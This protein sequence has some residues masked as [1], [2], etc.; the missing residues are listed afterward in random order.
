MGGDATTDPLPFAGFISYSRRN[1]RLAAALQFG[2]EQLAKPSRSPRRFNVFLDTDDIPA[3]GTLPERLAQGLGAA[4]KLVVL[5]SRD[6]A[7]S[8]WVGK[9]LEYWTGERDPHGRDIILVVLDEILEWDEQGGAS[10]V[11]GWAAE[12]LVELH[13][14]LHDVFVDQPNWVDLRE[15]GALSR[16]APGSP[17]DDAEVHRR[18]SLDDAAFKWHVARIQAPLIGPDVKPSDIVGED[19]EIHRAEERRRRRRVQAIV[20]LAA[21]AI[22]LGAIATV[23]GLISAA[24]AREAL[25]RQLATQSGDPATGLDLGPLLAIEAFGIDRNADSEGA[26]V[27]AAARAADIDVLGFGHTR[28]IRSVDVDADGEVVV[29]TDEAG[30][31]VVRRAADGEVIGSA[32]VTDAAGGPVAASDAELADAEGT[33]VV[34]G[35][36][37]RVHRFDLTDPS[38]PV[39][40]EPFEPIAGLGALSEIELLDGGRVAVVGGGLDAAG[41]CTRNAP[42][43]VVTVDLVTGDQIELGTVTGCTYSLA[44]ADGVVAAGGRDGRVTVVGSD[45][46]AV[47]LTAHESEVGALAISRDGRRLASAGFDGWVRIWSLPRL[48]TTEPGVRPTADV[49]ALPTSAI[50][51]S[52]AFSADGEQLAVGDREGAVVVLSSGTGGVDREFSSRH[53]GDVRGLVFA[54]AGDR[55]YSGASD[56]IVVAWRIGG[57]NPMTSVLHRDEAR[58]TTSAESATVVAGGSLGPADEPVPGF[59]DWIPI[60][61]DASAERTATRSAVFA[62]AIHRGVLAA[63]LVDG[64]IELIDTSSRELIRRIELGDR[65]CGDRDEPINPVR[66]VALGDRLLVAGYANGAV[67]VV[68]D[69]ATVDLAAASG[70]AALRCHEVTG[71]AWGVALHPDGDLVAATNGDSRILLWSLPDDERDVVAGP[72]ELTRTLSFDPSGRRVVA[73]GAGGTVAVLDAATGEPVQRALAG[74]TGSVVSA[75]FSADGRRLVTAGTDGVIRLWDVDTGL[76][77]TAPLR[78]SSGL[79]RGASWAADDQAVLAVG[80]DGAVVWDLRPAA[81]RDQVC[82]VVRRDMTPTEWSAYVGDRG[83]HTTCGDR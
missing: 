76:P 83:W 17:E 40:L 63:G 56:G 18:L 61:G 31:V 68:D 12:S 42:S 21:V 32:A 58:A 62:V 2:L 82:R 80:P 79:L 55:L 73:G 8:Y 34:A 54:P 28:S 1:R 72:A 66:S 33:L 22:V 16:V 14:V 81:L 52:L 4:G 59:V 6:A 38:R 70:T 46:V 57:A 23:L 37:G 47:D 69:P 65:L 29:D 24:Q 71:R 9:E 53:I 36:D 44:V 77:V 25:A 39:E 51:R 7:G 78:S 13:P 67:V 60:G 64:S 48:L 43:P 35:R 49:E 19:L 75:R 5:V 15:Y 41:T 50:V 26:L 3:G 30:Q 11:G 45:G 10:G 27:G 20:G 74:H